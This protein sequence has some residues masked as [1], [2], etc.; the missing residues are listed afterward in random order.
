MKYTIDKESKRQFEVEGYVELEGVVSASQLDTLDEEITKVLQSREGKEPYLAGRDL[1][2]ESPFLQKFFCHNRFSDIAKELLLTPLLHLGA[3]QLLTQ[4][5]LFYQHHFP[6][7]INL[8]QLTS[9]RDTEASFIIALDTHDELPE[10]WPKMAGNVL[11]IS[12]KTELNLAELPGSASF[13]LFT[14][15]TPNSLYV[16]QESDPNTH[17]LKTCG[18]VYG[19]RL[20][21]KGQPIALR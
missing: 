8:E 7:P 12:K 15:V 2:R 19:D 6:E 3:D 5:E 18:Y 1:W 9:I 20:T 13:L 10:P 16:Q 14:Y 4:D 21:S 17:Y 11:F